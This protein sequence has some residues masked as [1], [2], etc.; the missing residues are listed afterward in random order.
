[1]VEEQKPFKY[2]VASSARKEPTELAAMGD[3]GE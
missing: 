2:H 3:D 1:M